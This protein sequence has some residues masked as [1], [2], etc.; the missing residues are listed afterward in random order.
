MN[1]LQ[2]FTQEYL[3]RIFHYDPQ[4]GVIGR[5][6]P[7]GRWPVGQ[8]GT[9]DGKG[10]LHVN[11]DGAF[12]RLHRLGY[13]L[14]TGEI[15]DRIDHWDRDRHNNRLSNLRPCNQKDNTGNSGIA[16]HNTSG[17]RGVSRNTRSGK[18]HAQIKINGKQTYLGRFDDPVEASW[19]Y[20]E[21]AAK[22]FGEFAWMNNV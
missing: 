17:I 8:V 13:F 16:S 15:P 3:A 19:A 1:T 14:A 18:W 11:L 4:T 12:I 7:R 2:G 22:H 6:I 10:Y 5:K 21:A 20:D 9:V